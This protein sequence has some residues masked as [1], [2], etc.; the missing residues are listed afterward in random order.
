MKPA[1]NSYSLAWAIDYLGLLGVL[2]IMLIVFGTQTDYFWTWQNFITIANQLPEF[3]LLAIGMTFVL[4]IGGIDL[5]VGSVFALSGIVTG[6]AA[7]RWGWPIPL[8]MPLGVFVGG[9]CGFLNG[10]VSEKWKIP[11]FIVTLGMLEIARGSE[12]LIAKSETQ[13]IGPDIEFW[14]RPIVG[15][16][17]APSVPLALFI[18]VIAQIVLMKTV[19]GRYL[20]A[21]GDN[22]DAV[23]LSGI[24]ARPVKVTVFVISGLLAGLAGL[25]Q[26]SRMGSADPAVG[27]GF[28]LSAIAAAVIGGTSLMG[29]RGSILKSF[30]GVL[31]I[32]V[33][34][35]GLVQLDTP[36]NAR[37]IVT[38]LVIVLAV[39]LDAYRQQISWG[40]LRARLFGRRKTVA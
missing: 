17:I 5:S 6:V 25:L 28:E 9:C 13:Y 15:I 19:F 10:F 7:V 14:G 11:S 39:I 21:I 36:F 33:L 8:A 35:S 20:F 37:R 16:G 1:S 12:L 38:G 23:R 26:V 29:G 3:T 24:Y 34:D 27:V 2:A 18:V 30:L 40:D 22:E 32:A 4:I 31:V